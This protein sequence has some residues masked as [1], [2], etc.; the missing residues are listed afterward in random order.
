MANS[1][2]ATAEALVVGQV[3]ALDDVA[4]VTGPISA[5]GV[6]NDDAPTLAGTGEPGSTVTVYDNGTPIG[7]AVVQPD[8]TWSF[9]PTTPLGEGEHSITTTATDAGGNVSDA[10]DPIAF[11]VDTLAPTQSVVISA[12]T[13]DVDPVTG[14]IA[15]GGATND[16][17]PTLTGSISS[18]LQAG[19]A[20]EVLRNGVAIGEATVSGTSWSFQ[21][22]GLLDGQTYTYTARV[23][24]AAG[25]VGATSAP[26]GMT[27]Q[28]AGSSTS[29][30]ILTVIDDQEPQTG[31]VA[32]NGFTND[33][34]PE[35]QG[36][37]WARN[38][39]EAVPYLTYGNNL[40]IFR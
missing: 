2:F 38:L 24:D 18:P 30:S 33:L 40:T 3:G 13:D 5:G 11:T 39:I 27:L 29:V 10:S 12:I 28:T 17:T 9:T 20:L 15:N 4:P 8:G 31:S 21:D 34:S 32:H 36:Q 1:A 25:N 26:Y 35:I 22:G 7:T 6:T 14:V 23:V 19:E 37:H 16:A